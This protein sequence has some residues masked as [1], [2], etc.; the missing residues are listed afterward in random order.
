MFTFDYF[1]LSRDT[2]ELERR[3]K[4]LLRCAGI[5]L[6]QAATRKDRRDKAAAKKMKQLASDKLKKETKERKQKEAE[7]R[8]QKEIAEKQARKAE[9][10]RNWAEKRAL[11]AAKKGKRSRSRG[12]RKILPEGWEVHVVHRKR[13]STTGSTDKYYTGP[14]S[15]KRYRS[16]KEVERYLGYILP[17]EDP[18]DDEDVGGKPPKKKSRKGKKNGS[19][20]EET[21]S[22][23]DSDDSDAEEETAE[24][25]LKRKRK[26]YI[27]KFIKNNAPKG[28]ATAYIYY[29]SSIRPEIALKYPELS[30]T[31]VM[32]IIGPMWKALSKEE[33]APWEAKSAIKKKEC[34]ALRKIFD[35]GP[36]KEFKNG[37][38]VKMLKK[39]A[40]V[41]SSD[42]SSSEDESDSEDDDDVDDDDDDDVDD[43]DDDD[44]SDDDDDDDSDDDDSESDSDD[45]EKEKIAAKRKMLISKFIKKNAP[46]GA[47]S[48]YLLYMSSIRDSVAAKNPNLKTTEIMKTIGPMWKALSKEEK[49]PW[50][51]K[52]AARRVECKALRKKFN[53]GP[54]AEF[55]KGP[56]VELMDQVSSEDEDS[57]DD[58]D[59]DDDQP[60]SKRRK[61]NNSPQKPIRKK[62]AYLFYSMSRR[63]SLKKEL[64]AAILAKASADKATAESVVVA[65]A[66]GVTE[67]SV[68]VT[69]TMTTTTSLTQDYLLTKSL[70]K[71]MTTEWKQMTD[72]QK[73]PYVQMMKEDQARYERESE[74]Y[75]ENS[76]A[77]KAEEDTTAKLHASGLDKLGGSSSSS[78][79]SSSSSS[80]GGN[81]MMMMMPGAQM[82][83]VDMEYSDIQTTGMDQRF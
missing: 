71:I 60:P 77:K 62:T 66:A 75:N 79:K 40:E 52:S 7:E 65:A 56:L 12:V 13:G 83:A 28:G 9:R 24:E 6:T 10:E 18:N 57:D 61:K 81:G 41:Y 37:P 78:S 20:S 34:K 39:T 69:T 16:Y 54:L 26:E 82:G 11:K 76:A 68:P 29:M 30:T 73:A 14:D 43:D 38:L 44:D 67:G 63:K 50:E 59:G 80:N 51:A 42:E 1:F 3:C 8:R 48:A 17:A 21:S 15:T 58:D 53:E 46:K 5:H 33:K 2:I 31:E 23:E 70:T 47:P 45:D 4:S 32:K 27:Q 74:V 55:I 35:E 72:E 19:S 25:R 22:E 36:L 64:D 49:A